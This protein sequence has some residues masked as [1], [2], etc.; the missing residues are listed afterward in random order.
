MQTWN[1]LWACHDMNCIVILPTIL[2]HISAWAEPNQWCLLHDC[3]TGSFLKFR[4]IQTANRLYKD[5]HDQTRK[6][7]ASSI[8]LGRSCFTLC[9]FFKAGQHEQWRA[10]P[11]AAMS[12]LEQILSWATKPLHSHI[13][14]KA[15]YTRLRG[16]AGPVCEV[17]VP[18]VW[19]YWGGKFYTVHWSP[20]FFLQIPRQE[21]LVSYMWCRQPQTGQGCGRIFF[22]V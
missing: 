17:G 7:I 11:G 16:G 5:H 22:H 8:S 1:A 18:W 14:T 19:A 20:S 6:V 2:A 10:L 4:L 13:Q 12:I 15:L 3:S 21:S 9:L